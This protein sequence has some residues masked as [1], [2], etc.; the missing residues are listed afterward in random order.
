MRSIAIIGSL[1]L[2]SAFGQTART[3]GRDWTLPSNLTVKQTG[4]QPGASPA[5]TTIS[6]PRAIS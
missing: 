5:T 6:T 3:E 2:A 1:A 4:P